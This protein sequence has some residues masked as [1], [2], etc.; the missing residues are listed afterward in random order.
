MQ[1]PARDGR[2]HAAVLRR[3]IAILLIVGAAV[4]IVLPAVSLLVDPVETPEPSASAAAPSPSASAAGVLEFREPSSD[5]AAW[6]R[7]GADLRRFPPHLQVGTMT[8]GATYDVEIPWPDRPPGAI[9]P[10]RIVVG[11]ADGVLVW[12]ADDGLNSVVHAVV[13]ESGA[14]FDLIETEEVILAAAV[15]DRLRRVGYITGNRRTGDPTGAWTLSLEGG[16]PRPINALIGAAPRVRL[17]AVVPRVHLLF[18]SPDGSTI[19]LFRC[20]ML[21]CTLRAVRVDNGA[22]IGDHALDRGFREPFAITE[23][24]ALLRPT[25]QDGP[26][27]FG[28]TM[29]LATGELTPLNVE[30]WPSFGEAVGEDDDGRYLAIQTAGASFPHE[31]GGPVPEPPEVSVIDLDSLELLVTHR[32]P[33]ATVLLIPDNDYGHGADLPPSWV[34]VQGSTPGTEVMRAYAL[35]VR[36]GQLVEL[37]ALGEWRLQG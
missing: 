13:A 32:P 28:E 9:A 24:L 12:I 20:E 11:M 33:L 29:D 26:E 23:R 16:A 17:A 1:R 19:A 31:F 2:H 7:L 6:Y 4:L 3:S 36:N 21:D 8:S 34:L 25:V 5:D 30:S 35:N 27:R 14:A 22:L 37:P 18:L 10:E 15:D